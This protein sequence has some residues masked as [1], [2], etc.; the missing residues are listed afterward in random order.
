MKKVPKFDVKHLDSM[1]IN[2]VSIGLNK[3]A[4]AYSV[5]VR[6]LFSDK[7]ENTDMC[8][9]HKELSAAHKQSRECHHYISSN[10][11]FRPYTELHYSTLDR[12]CTLYNDPCHSTFKNS[13]K[14]EKK[15][16]MKK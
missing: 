15:D 13:C 7:K 16:W 5:G 8:A 14:A 3:P 1:W 9:A 2:S 10:L 11:G 6:Q 12:V 4:D